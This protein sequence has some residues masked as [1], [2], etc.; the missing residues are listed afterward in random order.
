MVE[1]PENFSMNPEQV[2]Q[3]Q[4]Q[5]NPL[6]RYMRQP[7]IYIK[8]PSNGKFYTPGAIDM[9]VNGEIPVMP[10]STKDEITLNTPDA[11]MN[12]QGVVDM[13]HSCCPSIKNAWDIPIVD[14]DTILIG[15]RIASYGENMEY[16]SICPEC[17]NSDNYEIDLRQFMDMPVNMDIYNNYFDYKGMQIYIQ[18]IN[19]QTLNQQNLENF[20]QQRL[21]I[22]V[23][24]STL[25]GEEKQRRFTEIFNIMT[26][27]TVANIAGGI[28]QIITPEGDTVSNPDHIQEFVR[29]SERQFYNSLKKHLEDVNKGVPEKLVHT[30]C[31]SCQHKYATPFSFDQANFFAFAS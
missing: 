20:E 4:N 8:L 21:I 17:E 2:A 18:P 13:I 30:T 31:D 27:Y 16:T 5:T 1:V 23:N 28:N 14:L 6:Q 19:Y 11:L 7:S 9:P 26:N 3:M 29:N 24:D 25:S 15:I 10:M 22:M 12:G